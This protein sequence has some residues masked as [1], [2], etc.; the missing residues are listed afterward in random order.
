MNIAAHLACY[1]C[2]LIWSD[3]LYGH[4]CDLAHR[5]S[6]RGLMASLTT[7]GDRYSAEEIEAFYAEGFWKRESFYELAV[8]HAQER[9]GHM[10]VFD[11]TTAL[12]YAEFRVRALRL[13]VRL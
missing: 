7:V 5:D 6:G 1:Q 10:F 9:P 2:L 11:S 12:T 13:A 3:L 8:R 4:I